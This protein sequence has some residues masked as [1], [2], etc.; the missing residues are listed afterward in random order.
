MD[1]HELKDVD[2]QISEAKDFA[3]LKAVYR[4][5]VSHLQSEQLVYMAHGRELMS[6]QK[7]QEK[8]S[9]VLF[10][11]DEDLKNHPGLVRRVETVEETVKDAAKWFR[12]IMI[13]L[14]GLI[15]TSLYNAVTKGSLLQDVVK[16]AYNAFK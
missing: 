6:I 5:L 14:V 16:H 9:L 1:Y 4:R 2:R 13:T 10:G 12:W 7:E 3:E 15:V 11:K 8:H